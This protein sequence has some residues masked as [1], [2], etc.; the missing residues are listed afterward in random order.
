MEK[1]ELIKDRLLTVLKEHLTQFDSQRLELTLER[2]E[3][4]LLDHFEQDPS[5]YFVRQC[6][7]HFLY[8]PKDGSQLK[9]SFS[10]LEFIKKFK[11]DYDSHKWTSLI[12]KYFLDRPFVCLLGKPSVELAQQLQVAEEQR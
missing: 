12:K 7:T 10:Q 2:M 6:I 3:R 5:N 1:I 8:A 11:S 9:L 4:Q